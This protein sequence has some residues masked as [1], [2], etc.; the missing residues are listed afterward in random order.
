MPEISVLI[1]FRALSNTTLR[2]QPV[3]EDQ[4]APRLDVTPQETVLRWL[5]SPVHFGA[6]TLSKCS[7]SVNRLSFHVKGNVGAF[8]EARHMKGT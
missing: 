1:S 4:K 3:I 7:R 2:T 6:W 5:P 8:W